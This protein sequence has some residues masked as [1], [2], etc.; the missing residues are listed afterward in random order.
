MMSTQICSVVAKIA[1]SELSWEET[2]F[3]IDGLDKGEFVNLKAVPPAPLPPTSVKACLELCHSGRE[4]KEAQARA[5]FPIWKLEAA[6]S[7]SALPFFYFKDLLFTC[8][9]LR[10]VFIAAHGLFSLWRSGLAA[11]RGLVIAVA[12]LVER[13]L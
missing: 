5:K 6:P 3:W 8:L 7:Y 4:L 10:W 12:S 13:R 1:V 2:T 11:A 9:W